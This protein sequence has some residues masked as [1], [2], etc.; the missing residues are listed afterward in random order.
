M[1]AGHA[2]A[3]PHGLR[4][5]DGVCHRDVVLRP[6]TGREEA[7]LGSGAGTASAILAACVERI[8]GYD[9]I[10]SVMTAALTRGDRAHLLLHLRAAM[11]GDRLSLVVP[12]PSPACSALADMDLSIAEIAPARPVPAPELLEADTPEG[13][14]IL[15]EPT[16]ADD[17]IV[18]AASGDR[19]ARSTLMWSR[20]VVDLGG[21]GPLAPEQWEALAAPTRHAIAKRLAE[22][23][24]AP[25]L[26][27]VARCPSCPALLE[28]ELDPLAL[29]ERELRLGVDR[30]VVEIHCLAFHYHWSEAEILA[31]PRARRWRYLELVRRQIEGRPLIEAWS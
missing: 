18:A 1:E 8:G 19:R 9:E 6:L 26:V 7:A 4:D 24:S 3:L 31:L 14:A 27:F 21:R 2:T 30:L 12:C 25:D 28:V 29:L 17:E 20:L 5:E 23:T 16:G 10:D 11:F 13:R 15:R 22:A